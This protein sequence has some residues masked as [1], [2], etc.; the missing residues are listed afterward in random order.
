MR[1]KPD[2]DPSGVSGSSAQPRMRSNDDR[3]SRETC[4][5]EMPTRSAISDLRELV[6]EPHRHDRPLAFGQP[7][8]QRANHV[9]VLALLEAGVDGGQ[10]RPMI[11]SD[12]VVGR[13]A[14][15]A[16]GR[17]RRAGRQAGDDIV[18]VD[19]EVCGELGDRGRA[20]QGVLQL[21]GGPANREV[22]LL[23]AARA[24]APTTCG[25]GSGA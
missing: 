23:G 18:P 14:V 20:M 8:Q 6:E 2:V 13:R 9:A 17:V 22:Q 21:V 15:Q 1:L 7:V 10:C 25:R 16:A 11:G 12:G 4:I 24:P 5:C 3:S 19:A